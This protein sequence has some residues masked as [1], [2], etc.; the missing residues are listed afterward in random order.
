MGTTSRFRG[1]GIFV[2]LWAVLGSSTVHAW[3]VT[4]FQVTRVTTSYSLEHGG[5]GGSAY[6]L[7]CGD[8]QV[9]VGVNAR[10]GAYIDRIQGICRP[11]TGQGAWTGSESLTGTAGGSG[12]NAVTRRCPANH[13]VTGFTGRKG[14]FLGQVA[15][16]CTRLASGDSI[17]ITQRTVLSAFGGPGGT[18]FN[19]TRC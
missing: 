12:G 15:L 5:P 4:A 1:L 11:V 6:N 2:A 9:L 10:A 18:A 14:A 13:A 8:G 16:E 3:T 19:T 17:D 7:S